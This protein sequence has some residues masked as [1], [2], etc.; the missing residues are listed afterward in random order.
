MQESKTQNVDEAK[1]QIFLP[2]SV[3]DTMMVLVGSL[4]VDKPRKDL[5]SFLQH[6]FKNIC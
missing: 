1:N 4:R 5:I 2:Q 6:I 3:A